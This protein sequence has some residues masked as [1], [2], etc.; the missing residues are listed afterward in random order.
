MLT[1]IWVWVFISPY[2]AEYITQD[3]FTALFVAIVGLCL[4]IYS[5]YNP[6]TFKF[7]NNQKEDCTCTPS[8]EEQVL[9]DEYVTDPIEKIDKNSDFLQKVSK[10]EVPII[11]LI[12]KID[13][14][15]E[16]NLV[17]LVEQW[18]EVLP[19]AEIVPI[20]AL[21][22]R[23]INELLKVIKS[24]LEEGPQYFPDYMITDQPERVLVSELIREKVFDPESLVI[25]T[26]QFKEKLLNGKK[27][28]YCPFC[29][30]A[31]NINTARPVFNEYQARQYFMTLEYIKEDSK[32]GAILKSVTIKS[33]ELLDVECDIKA[34][35]K[36]F[37]CKDKSEDYTGKIVIGNIYFK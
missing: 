23:N 30:T 2:I 18:H 34:A 15:D 14:T 3:Q 6:N 28:K 22:G 5:S 12:N 13:L 7:L 11:V 27:V 4:A 10:M 32:K 33:G 17:A 9:N 16:K 29:N 25:P 19:L 37:I 8:T 24:H 21:K 36:L 20:S 26:A 1:Y 35:N 31:E